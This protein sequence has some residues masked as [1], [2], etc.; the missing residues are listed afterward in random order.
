MSNGA[1]V[2]ADALMDSLLVGETFTVPSVN[3]NDP[4]FSFPSIV[5]NP[6]YAQIAKLTNEDLTTRTVGG[7]GT[8][9]AIMQS[10]AVH[11]QQEFTAGRI[12]GA[13]Y[14][15]AYV[16]LAQSA[17]SQAVQYLLGKDQAYWAGVIAQGQALT[18]KVQLE[19]AKAQLAIA[20]IEVNNQ[21]ATYALNKIRLANED[22]QY[23]INKYNLDKLLPAQHAQLTAQTSLTTKQT[24]AIDEEI[25]IKK[26]QVLVSVA[27]VGI[28]QAKLVNIPKEGAM[29]DAQ[30]LSV[31]KNTAVAE[32]NL[33]NLLPAQLTLV[34]EQG[35]VQRAQ[36]LEVRADGAAVAGSVKSQKDL[37]AQQV[38]SYKRSSEINAAKIFTDA[39]VADS[40]IQDS[41]IVP[42]AFSS[43]NI[44]SVL[45]SIKTLNGL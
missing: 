35:E 24:A 32:Y 14:A 37:Y 43:A 22:A 4:A 16:A 12:T 15:K 45:T 10:Q 33:T 20:L 9:D 7:S 1:E 28:A 26:Q 31:E 30:K 34:K 3:F 19:T 39:W 42:T 40:A 6:L 25:L 44:S 5:N 29:L 17:G 23:G 8:Y 36:T 13:E 27:E 21:R 38:I 18:A 41:P 2:V 11:L